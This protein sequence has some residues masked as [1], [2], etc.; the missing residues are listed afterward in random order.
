MKGRKRLL[1]YWFGGRVFAIGSGD[2]FL[3]LVR[4]TDGVGVMA[5][6]FRFVPP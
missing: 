3:L 6:F 1:C 5:R 2:V 4:G